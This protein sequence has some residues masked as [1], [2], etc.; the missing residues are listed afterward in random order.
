ML[1][2]GAILDRDGPRP[3]AVRIRAGAVVEV[4]QRGTLRPH[5][6]EHRLRG[7]VI[8]SPVNSHTHLGDAVS[9]REPP[10]GPVEDLVGGPHGY[11]FRLLASSTRAAKVKAVRAALS[12]MNEEGI[13]AVVDFREEGLDGVRLLRR[14]AR[15]QPVRVLILGRPLARPVDPAEVGEILA[16]ADGIGLSSARDETA[17]ARRSIARACR[18]AGKRFALHASEAVRERPETFLDPKPDLLVHL[19]KATEEDL[20]EVAADR[21]TVAV[22]PRSNALFGR[23]PNLAG[24]ERAGVSLLLGTDNAM[25][26]APSLWRELEFAYVAT[27]LKGRP[28]SAGYLAR[29]ALVEPYRWLGTPEAASVA[30]DAPCRPL[31]LRLPAD[32]PEYQV[33]TRTAEHLILRPVRS[34]RTDRPP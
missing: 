20:L 29:A 7:I 17:T 10:D 8:P 2:E 9:V 28:V 25:F 24:M 27:R 33:V 6:D 23:Q 3:A 14:A 11:K 18:A 13:E 32:D 26:H 34:R 31:V 1:V 21:V 12:R 16:E 5:P 15:N 19:A 30:V 22:C 4:G